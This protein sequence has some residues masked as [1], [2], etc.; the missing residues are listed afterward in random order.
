MA[1]TGLQESSRRLQALLDQLGESS[2]SVQ[3]DIDILRKSGCVAEEQLAKFEGQLNT[4]LHLAD[5]IR[6]Q[7]K[8]R[9]NAT[10]DSSSHVVRFPGGMESNREVS[11]D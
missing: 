11:N 2:N 6:A 8:R 1:Q 4:L 3:R 10:V 5:S 7:A 9:A